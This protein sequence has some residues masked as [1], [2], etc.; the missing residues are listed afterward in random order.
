[1]PGG[2]KPLARA[3]SSPSARGEEGPEGWDEGRERRR[4]GGRSGGVEGTQ[5]CRLRA[6]D[7]A[8]ALAIGGVS[9]SAARER[10]ASSAAKTRGALAAG[11]ELH[12]EVVA[13]H[14]AAAELPPAHHEVAKP[15]VQLR[16]TAGDVQRIQLRRP[17]EH[18][19]AG[20]DHVVGHHFGPQGRGVDVAMVAGLVAALAHVHLQGR[21][22]GRA[23]LARLRRRPGEE[24]RV[25]G[26]V[27]IEIFLSRFCGRRAV[28]QR[29]AGRRGS[30]GGL[31]PRRGDH[32]GTC[33]S[34]IGVAVEAS[35]GTA[36]PGDA[37]TS[38]TF[39][40]AQ[41]DGGEGAV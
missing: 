12:G 21:R 41:W 7:A 23:Q 9:G 15:R 31:T 32:G 39:S 8:A 2:T 19:E 37:K 27:T 1:M 17:R 35:R 5:P 13:D 11:L 6:K 28:G 22:S 3:R 18:V 10:T 20:L 36:R 34:A 4:R 29:D 40:R 14:H 30:R 24:R 26:V 25:G 16:R 33:S 38:S